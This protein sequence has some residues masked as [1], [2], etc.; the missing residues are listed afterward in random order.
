MYMSTH[1]NAHVYIHVCTCTCTLSSW[2]TEKNT[3]SLA[4]NHICSITTS[5]IHVH[6]MWCVAY[7]NT[8]RKESHMNHSCSTSYS[9]KCLRENY[10]CFSLFFRKPANLISENIITHTTWHDGASKPQKLNTQTS[11]FTTKC[12]YVQMYIVSL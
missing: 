8:F 1:V 7:S 4:Q 11:L 5:Y 6:V 2:E 12:K 3:L 10:F 9:R